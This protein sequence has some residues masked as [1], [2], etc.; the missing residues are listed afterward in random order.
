M[1]RVHTSGGFG[2]KEDDLIK[3]TI[4]TYI[5]LVELTRVIE[6]HLSINTYKSLSRIMSSHAD[7]Q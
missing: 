5:L 1:V 2:V 3:A 4:A 6:S 7:S